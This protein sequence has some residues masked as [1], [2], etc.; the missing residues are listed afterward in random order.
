MFESGQLDAISLGHE[1][2]ENLLQN[3]EAE[4]VCEALACREDGGNTA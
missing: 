1:E 2:F 3:D 4:R